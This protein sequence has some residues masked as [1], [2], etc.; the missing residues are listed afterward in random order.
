LPPQNQVKVRN[1]LPKKDNL[2]KNG[3]EMIRKLFRKL[4]PRR[5]EC[6][7]QCRKLLDGKYGL[8]IGGPSRIF[9]KKGLLPI[10]PV[11]GRLDNC[12]FSS[13]TVW[14]GE[15]VEGFNYYFFK[16]RS[17]G[18]QYIRDAVRLENIESGTYDFILSCHNLEHIANPFAALYEWMRVLKDH[19]YL[20][21]ILP[22]KDATFDHRRPVTPLS[23]LIDD[24]KNAIGED[25]LTHLPEIFKLHDLQMDPPAGTF[26]EFKKRSEDNLN[27]RCL[28][29]H[30]FDTNLVVEVLNHIGVQIQAV[31]AISPRHII[32][33][34]ERLSTGTLPNNTCFRAS[35][36]GFRNKS[37]F[38]S[39]RL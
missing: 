11:I 2:L 22:H 27:N 36:A 21:V 31:E 39:D 20:I 17:P 19:A 24:F 1:S 23:H 38:N 6:S 4:I 37:P 33:I 29:H 7:K 26:D 9:R 3:Q 15:L 25:D 32:V 16:G 35:D 28:H 34:A 8:E 14:E 18:F 5:A 12:N 13:R 30:V 10:Y